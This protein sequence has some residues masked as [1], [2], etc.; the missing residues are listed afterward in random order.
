MVVM[1]AQISVRVESV[2]LVALVGISLDNTRLFRQMPIDLGRLI[3]SAR[4][5]R[6]TA[7]ELE[8]RGGPPL[9]QLLE[10][11]ADRARG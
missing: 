5:I 11:I 7:Y 10:P 1:A 2:H 9:E 4:P 6:E 3:T 8:Q